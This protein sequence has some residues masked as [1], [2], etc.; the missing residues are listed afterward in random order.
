MREALQ[1]KGEDRLELRALKE[2]LSEAKKGGYPESGLFETLQQAVEEAEKCEVV[3]QQLC[4]K[5]K[6]YTEDR[7]I[8]RYKFTVEE[9]QLFYDQLVF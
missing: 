6:R 9:L 5:N 8:I 4:R 2:M 7:S 1:A 3:A